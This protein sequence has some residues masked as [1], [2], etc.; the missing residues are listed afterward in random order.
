MNKHIQPSKVVP[1][2]ASGPVAEAINNVT[3]LAAKVGWAPLAGCSAAYL[4]HIR[5][6]ERERGTTP[7]PSNPRHIGRDYER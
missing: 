1:Q 6:V 2:Q 7:Q 5:Q 4:A 3:G